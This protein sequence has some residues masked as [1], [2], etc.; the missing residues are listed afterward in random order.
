MMLAI[1]TPTS[2]ANTAAPVS[3][4]AAI[5]R[6]CVL[7]VEDEFIVALNLSDDLD[8]AGFE[9]L[10]PASSV[11]EARQ[12]LQESNCDAAVLDVNLGVET[13]A[14]IARDLIAQGVP[15]IVASG[16]ARSQHPAIFN[17]LPM[18]VKPVRTDI[19]VAELKRMLQIP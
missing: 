13:S 7:L 10:G 16:Y 15:I 6:P 14:P 8:S 18:I 19:L 5:R 17:G 4:G 3:G 2:T 9:V 11:A 1:P 12:L